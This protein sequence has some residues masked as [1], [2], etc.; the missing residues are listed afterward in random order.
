MVVKDD[1]LISSV[2]PLAFALKVDKINVPQGAVSQGLLVMNDEVSV[3]GDFYLSPSDFSVIP[4]EL[5]VEPLEK[6]LDSPSSKCL[7]ALVPSLD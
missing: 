2:S 5:V 1:I 4:E 6:D 3:N 7:E